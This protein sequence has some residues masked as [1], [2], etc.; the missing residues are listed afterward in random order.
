MSMKKMMIQTFF[1]YQ[2]SAVNQ[3]YFE[4]RKFLDTTL[5]WSTTSQSKY[6][7]VYYYYIS[8]AKSNLFTCLKRRVCMQ[9]P[10]FIWVNVEQSLFQLKH[11][12]EF[13]TQKYCAHKWRR[14]FCMCFCLPHFRIFSLT[15][16]DSWIR[17]F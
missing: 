6:W 12:M 4:F 13:I 17:S 7:F 11:H 10:S 15:P 14:H 8:L 2:W 5:T 3:K 1:A 9:V 16:I